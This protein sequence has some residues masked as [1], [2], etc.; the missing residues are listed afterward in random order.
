MP[1][2]GDIDLGGFRSLDSEIIQKRET[3]RR[4]A[5]QLA[6]DRKALADLERIEREMLRAM[7][8]N[9]RPR[10]SPAPRP[11]VDP[12][13]VV[14]Y[15]RGHMVL[16]GNPQK[17]KPKSAESSARTFRNVG[18]NEVYMRPKGSITLT[19]TPSGLLGDS[20]A[21][22]LPT[23]AEACADIAARWERKSARYWK[24]RR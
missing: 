10:K 6:A 21:D 12:R 19:G 18:L 8:K 1:N 17:G 22:S 16:K 4:D 20:P 9:P 11:V 5:A 15:V 24:V 2:K 23:Y 3:A 14:P 7:G 13:N